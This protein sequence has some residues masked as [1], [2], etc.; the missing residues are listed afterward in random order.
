MN[1]SGN[2]DPQR[3]QFVKTPALPPWA[4]PNGL[5]FEQEATLVGLIGATASD[6]GKFLSHFKVQRL[7]DLT[8]D[9]YDGTLKMLRSKAKSGQ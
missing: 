3:R 9:Q 1:R 6:F 7:V 2:Y 4:I 8:T 5:S